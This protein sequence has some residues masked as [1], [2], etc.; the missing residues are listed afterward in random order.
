MNTSVLDALREHRIMAIARG[1]ANES[2]DDAAEALCAGGIRLIEVTLNTPGALEIIARWCSR[3]EGRF[4]GR[5]RVGAG[6]VLDE[7]MARAAIGAG[8]EFLVSPNVDEAV[9]EHGLRSE[10]EVFPGALSPTEIVRAWKAGAHAVKVFPASAFGPKYLRELRGPLGQIPLIAV[11]GVDVDN[12]GDFLQAGAVG[13][14][15][16]SSLV[17]L[18]LIQS[19]RFDELQ[20][21]AQRCVRA[22]RG[23][24]QGEARG[25]ARGEAP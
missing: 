24:A 8:A 14:G 3:F 6:T 19:G 20:V 12:L 2:A 1:L 11:G 21:L 13:V 15:L 16:G 25:E 23:E 5:M 10:V 17:S 18:E 7:G 4:E 9:I 22:A